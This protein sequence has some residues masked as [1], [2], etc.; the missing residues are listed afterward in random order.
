VDD[1]AGAGDEGGTATPGPPAVKVKVGDE[2][3]DE[4]GADGEVLADGAYF[5]DP[6]F[7]WL[8]GPLTADFRGLPVDAFAGNLGEELENALDGG[9]DHMSSRF[10][11]DGVLDRLAP[12]SGGGGENMRVGA[13]F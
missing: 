10:S 13:S 3:V 5:R 6:R 9:K 12:S 8:R 2:T 7:G 11:G 1:L 4:A